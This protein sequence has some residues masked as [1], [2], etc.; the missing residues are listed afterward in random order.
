MMNRITRIV[1]MATVGL[2]SLLTAT[3]QKADGAA[4]AYNDLPFEMRAVAEPKIPDYEVRLTDFGG[5]ADGTTMNTEAFRKA[6]AALAQRGGGRLTVARGVWL[7]GPIELKSNT[8]LHLEEGALVLFSPNRADYP[9]VD[10]Y[11][12]G[13]RMRRCMSP[14]TAVNAENIA[15]TGTGVFN[16]NGQSWRPVKRGKMTDGQWKALCKGGALNKKGDVWYPTEQIRD[17]DADRDKYYQRVYSENTDEAWQELHDYLRPA[18]LSFIGCKRVLLEDA[19]FENS[20]AWNIHPLMCEDLTVRNVTIRNPWYSQNGDGLDIESCSN[21]VVTGCSFDVGDDAMCIKSGRDEEGRKRAMPTQN[22]VIRD[23]RVYHGHGGF[24]IGS[25]MSGGARNIMVD[26]CLF[27]GTDTGLRFKSTRGRGG[28]VEDIFIRNIGMADIPGD[29]ITFDLYYGGKAPLEVAGKGG[30]QTAAPIPAVDETT[31]SFRNISVEGVT[32]NG[33]K[34]AIYMNGLPEMPIKDIKIS[35]STF[36][37]QEGAILNYTDGLTLD[38]VKI[39]AADGK[40]IK[41]YNNVT[42]LTVK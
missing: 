18:L 4:T 22:V 19:T 14:L 24:V 26:N 3:A 41:K 40:A 30:N 37:A 1:A 2:A 7:T 38:G 11:F 13:V 12:E 29:A 21:V 16:G 20:P 10:S 9:L 6:I 5:V 23:C 32:C 31:P 8:E 42:N 27:I 25:E 35:R 34:R 33:A 15:I 36:K 17:I 39:T 28:T